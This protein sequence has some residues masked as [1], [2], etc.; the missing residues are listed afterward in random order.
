[1]PDSTPTPQPT[2]ASDNVTTLTPAHFAQ[3]S[4][5][6]NH[7][8]DAVQQLSHVVAEIRNLLLRKLD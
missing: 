3:L 1:M 8:T 4:A 5:S 6:L 2:E 7:L